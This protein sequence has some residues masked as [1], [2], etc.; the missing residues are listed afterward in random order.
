VYVIL[1]KD[2][3]VSAPIKINTE[4][5][6][7]D[8]IPIWGA[9]FYVKSNGSN[10]NIG[11]TDKK[12]LLTVAKALEKISN[13]YN[14][15]WPGKKDDD[16]VSATIVIMDEV[17]VTDYILI[18]GTDY[19]P[20]VLTDERRGGQ[21]TATGNSAAYEYNY[22]PVLLALENGADVTLEGGLIL[23]GITGINGV[24][25][26]LDASFTMTGGEIWDC[27]IGV[28]NRPLMASPGRF[29]MTGGEIRGSN[30]GVCL[31]E[32]P[33]NSGYW[34]CF[35]KTGGTVYGTDM[36]AGKAVYSQGL[37]LWGKANTSGPEDDLFHNYPNLG[38]YSGSWD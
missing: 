12:P 3:K 17:T 13:A 36:G 26:E 8:V 15:E 6:G 24:Y 28:S 35:Q 31:G 19:P 34:L 33:S 38:D 21:L 5:G 11:E 37:S 32:H 7:V 25:L 20:I 14:D 27:E 23:E 22:T 29:I 30:I 1:F 9:T 4:N 10:T 16:P 2:G 18:D